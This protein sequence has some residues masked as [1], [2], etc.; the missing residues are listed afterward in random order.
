M[1]CRCM[2]LPKTSFRTLELP[3]LTQSAYNA[4]YLTQLQAST[5]K[6]KKII[7]VHRIR[8][9]LRS[10]G[11]TMEPKLFVLRLVLQYKRP[12]ELLDL[13]D[14]RSSPEWEEHT[15]T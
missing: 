8:T 14:I 15:R 1:V 12:R 6:S 4:T 10:H 3:R 11:Y 7:A 5:K 9:R 2:G 13:A